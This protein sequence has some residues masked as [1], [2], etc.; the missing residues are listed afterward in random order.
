M[1]SLQPDFARCKER[2][3]PSLLFGA[4]IPPIERILSM[5]QPS[6]PTLRAESVVGSIA[7]AAVFAAF[8]GSS[9]VFIVVAGVLIANSVFNSND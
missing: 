5:T 1:Y 3:Y 6:H 7:I 4:A 8:T 9:L 2:F